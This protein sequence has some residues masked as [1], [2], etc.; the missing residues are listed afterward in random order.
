MKEEIEQLKNQMILQKSFRNKKI[1]FWFIRT[2]ILCLIYLLLPK[3][4]WIINT[5]W[6]TVPLSLFSLLSILIWPIFL[7]RKIQKIES[8]L[9]L[10]DK[11]I[12][13]NENT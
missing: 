5:L 10:L 11:E 1:L 7:K 6:F 4:E 3:L 2:F 8:K 12:K 9:T 13:A